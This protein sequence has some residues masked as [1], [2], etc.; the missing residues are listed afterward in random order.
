M[1]LHVTHSLHGFLSKSYTYK[2]NVHT[3]THTH[4]YWHCSL[5]PC[6]EEEQG[7]TETEE[8]ETQREYVLG[9]DERIKEVFGYSLHHS[10]F[11]PQTT[12]FEEKGEPKWIRTKVPVLTI[13]TSWPNRLTKRG[14]KNSFLLMVGVP[15][16]FADRKKFLFYFRIFYDTHFTIRPLFFA[17]V[18]EKFVPCFNVID[19]KYTLLN[20]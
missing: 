19:M 1:G 18:T 5:T 16:N 9:P 2:C 17:T 10:F 14:G 3:H 13:L 7:E 6:E 4:T 12:T 20:T 15:F 8:I 11:G